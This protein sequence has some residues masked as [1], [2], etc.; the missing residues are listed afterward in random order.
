MAHPVGII[1]SDRIVGLELQS[2]TQPLQ[3]HLTEIG[4]CRVPIGDG[5]TRHLV[6]TEDV[7]VLNF[8]RHRGGVRY[9][10]LDNIRV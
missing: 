9:G 5:E 1:F 7:V 4:D 6:F 2:V 8:L 10:L 3:R